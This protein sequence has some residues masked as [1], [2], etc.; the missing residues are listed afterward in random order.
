VITLSIELTLDPETAL[1]LLRAKAPDID[2][3]AEPTAGGTRLVWEMPQPETDP[4]ELVAWFAS[5]LVSPAKAE[6]IG[7]WFTDR[8]ARRPS[9][10][11]AW[12]TYAEPLYH[13][14]NFF[15]LLDTLALEPGDELL[16]VGCGGG[17]LL[18]RAL[19]SGC[20]AA[21]IDHSEEMV[22][23]AREQ[24]AGAIAEGRLEI[25]QGDAHVLPFADERFT[26]AVST[27]VFGFLDDPLTALLEVHR[28]LRPGGLLAIFCGT[29]ELRG[30]PA[31]PE[32]VASRI[33]WYD[34]DE[35]ERLALDAGFGDVTV[36]RPQL[37][38]YAREAGLPEDALPLFA[39]SGPSYAQLLVARK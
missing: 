33:H 7:D 30:T 37:E 5:E 25:V 4:G 2:V 13:L 6:Q 29:K 18:R 27:G 1:A 17:A 23:L 12:A 16:E 9:G 39:D 14:P 26:A 20:R 24:N 35:L 32:P 36:T 28:T 21:A 3:R 34:D 22:Q 15:L 38:R 11:R 31:A 19:R 10:S 8:L